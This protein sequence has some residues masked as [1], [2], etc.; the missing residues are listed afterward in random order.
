MTTLVTVLTCAAGCQR[1]RD[2]RGILD[3]LRD[4]PLD[5]HVR[6][7]TVLGVDSGRSETWTLY[8]CYDAV[9]RLLYVGKTDD[10]TRR[11]REHA[12]RGPWWSEAARVEMRLGLDSQE[13]QRAEREAILYERPIHNVE[14]KTA[15]PT[16]PAVPPPSTSYPPTRPA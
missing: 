16:P 14:S 13:A 1:P 15:P 4:I 7:H 10:W 3:G 2:S 9:G 6:T 8:R 5:S 12:S 11:Q